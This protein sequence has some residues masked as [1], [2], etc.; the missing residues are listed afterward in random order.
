MYN[1]TLAYCTAIQLGI[2]AAL[3][4]EAL[5]KFQGVTGRFETI[6]NQNGATIVID[7][8][9]TSDA[10]AYCLDTAKQHG[11]KRITHILGFRGDRDTEKREKML[12]V[13]CEMSDEYILTF[14]DLNSVSPDSMVNTLQELHT[15]HGNEK[16]KIITDRTLAIQ[17][18]IENSSGDDWILI[19]GKGHETYRQSFQLA[20]QSDKDTVLYV[21][22]NK[23]DPDA[24]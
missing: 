13:T 10:I 4:K 12:S 2:D 5:P 9:H 18:A 19:T 8:A 23:N 1:T 24:S 20:T 22:N 14:D 15:K 17:K 6:K 21:T 16:G 3:L 7:Y 11:A